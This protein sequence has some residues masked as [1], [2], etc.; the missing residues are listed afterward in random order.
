M[1]VLKRYYCM[2]G[3]IWSKYLLWVWC[4]K[5]SLSKHCSKALP[6]HNI[7]E[8]WQLH[9]CHRISI[10]LK[11]WEWKVEGLKVEWKVFL[12]REMGMKSRSA[13]SQSSPIWHV[14]SW[15]FCIFGT[16]MSWCIFCVSV[17]HIVLKRGS[18]FLQNQEQ[19]ELCNRLKLSRGGVASP[20]CEFVHSNLDFYKWKF[21]LSVRLSV[22]TSYYFPYSDSK[23]TQPPPSTLVTQ[24]FPWYPM[25]PIHGD[26]DWGHW[27]PWET[28]SHARQ[29]TGPR[30]PP[31]QSLIWGRV[32][33]QLDISKFGLY[34]VLFVIL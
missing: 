30:G 19:L 34:F 10:N 21:C 15:W 18:E 1:N 26:K 27:I 8:I 25:S 22:I 33:F 11:K 23:I 24:P 6:P 28:S 14:G 9:A 20:M 7:L 29:S 16:K 13:Q 12:K 5:V 2:S 17:F 4:F 31:S 32:T 3:K